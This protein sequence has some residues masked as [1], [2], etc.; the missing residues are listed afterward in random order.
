M[1]DAK[2]LT[3]M[4][5]S[6]ILDTNVVIK[7]F[8]GDKN[9]VN[10]TASSNLIYIQTIVFGELFYGAYNSK[11]VKSNIEKLE[12]YFNSCECLEC[13]F[14]TSKFYGNIKSKLKLAG[15]PIPENDIWI[16]AL[17]MQHNI[18]LVTSDSH[19]KLIKD[20]KLLNW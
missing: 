17:S 7:F 19:F 10:N 4:S 2:I 14:E 12:Q 11:N 9:V 1:K 16:A 15:K 20:L 5:G 18:P 13:N 3:K 6:V 8:G